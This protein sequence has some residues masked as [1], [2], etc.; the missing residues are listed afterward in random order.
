MTTT[1]PTTSPDQ[2]N[3][4]PISTTPPKHYKVVFDNLDRTL[5]PRDMRIDAQNKSIHHVQI[6]SV[7]SRIDY[8]S[9]SQVPKCNSGE[10]NL[11][12]IL[13][14]ENDYTKLKENF[15]T[16]IARILVKNMPFFN[17]FTGLVPDHINHQFSDNMSMKSE[18]VSETNTFPSAS[19]NFILFKI[20]STRHPPKM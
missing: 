14:S 17:D 13:P 20:G 7:R 12:D 6:Y 11:F 15:N 9:L 3:V 1:E 16:L 5:K 4:S 8:L 19:M 10:I 18:V 2:R